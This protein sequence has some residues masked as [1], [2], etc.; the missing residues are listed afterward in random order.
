MVR[1][2]VVAM[3]TVVMPAPV[4]LLVGKGAALVMRGSVAEATPVLRRIDVELSSAT[5]PVLRRTEVEASA[6]PVAKAESVEDSTALELEEA[7]AVVFDLLR[8]RL[9]LG[10]E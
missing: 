4:P 8:C 10:W 3:V 7:I 1:T 2:E 5:T 9:Y 6:I